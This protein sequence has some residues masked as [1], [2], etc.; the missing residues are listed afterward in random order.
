M[1]IYGR[2]TTAALAI[3][4]I[5]AFLTLAPAP[6]QT[7]A[8]PTLDERPYPDC[9]LDYRERNLAISRAQEATACIERIDAYY[10]DVLAPFE[11]AMTAYLQAVGDEPSPETED[12]PFAPYRAAEARY[13]D[14]R[15]FLEERFCRYAECA[16]Y[17]PSAISAERDAADGM[18]QCGDEPGNTMFVE[19]LLGI[20]VNRVRDIDTGTNFTGM[21]V[22]F[23]CRL[24]PEERQLAGAAS[25]EVIAREEVGATAGWI[26]P[27]R[28]EVSGSSTVT[29]MNSEPAGA[30]CLDITDVIIIEGEEARR[31]RTMCREPGE[32]RYVLRA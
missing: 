21:M 11:T 10:A 3:G 25:D 13:R 6:A 22:E 2:S 14:D 26:S 4:L 12:G 18:Q 20:I 16:D 5:G 7:P 28:P 24:R 9:R 19:G 1:A 27:T 32:A 8:L 29:A 30:T 17:Q 31:T 15:A 23:A